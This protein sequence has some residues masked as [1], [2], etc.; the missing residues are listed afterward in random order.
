MLE[1]S[2]IVFMVIILGITWG[3]FGFLLNMAY[4]KEKQKTS[5]E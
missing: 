3:T 1:L 4:R 2:T 5:K